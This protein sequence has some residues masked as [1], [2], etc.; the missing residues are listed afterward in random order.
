MSPSLGD[1]GPGSRSDI[2]RIDQRQIHLRDLVMKRRQ[3]QQF[4]EIDIEEELIPW[5]SPFAGPHPVAVPCSSTRFLVV[6]CCCGGNTG[7]ERQR[8]AQRTLVSI[9]DECDQIGYVG[10]GAKPYLFADRIAFLVAIQ[11]RHPRGGRFHVRSE[12]QVDHGMKSVF[13]GDG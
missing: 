1:L 6:G 9:D 13:V 11:Q 2:H 3:C 5:A 4:I 8:R 12:H 10:I 7:E